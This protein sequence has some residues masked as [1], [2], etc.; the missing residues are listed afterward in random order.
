MGVLTG[1]VGTGGRKVESLH[2]E[3]AC[4]GD[5]WRDEVSQLLLH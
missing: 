3:D 1:S 5:T 4:N 2:P